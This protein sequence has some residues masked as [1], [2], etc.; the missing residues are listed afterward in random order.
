MLN[1]VRD[2]VDSL[3]DDIKDLEKENDQLRSKLKEIK[4]GQTDIYSEVS[5][6]ERLTLRHQVI[7]LISKIDD[8]LEDSS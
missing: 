8:H 3:K 5:E 2:E 6:S 1:Q 7:G 4:D